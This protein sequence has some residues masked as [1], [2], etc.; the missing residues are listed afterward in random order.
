[1]TFDDEYLAKIEEAVLAE[2]L[3]YLEEQFSTH[4]SLVHVYFGANTW[5]HTAA[6]DGLTM[7]M[8]LLISLGCNVNAP[9]DDGK[10]WLP[11]NSVMISD[12]PE[13]LRILLEAGTD[14]NHDRVVISAITGQKKNSLV[15]LKLLE[16]FGANLNR[17]FMNELTNSPMN[18][19]TTAEDW[20]K[21]DVVDYLLSRRAVRPA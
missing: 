9:Q 10:E 1:M 4:P 18:A 3:P 17:V 16:Q 14:P 2:D 15:L 6:H 19:L 20:A 7:V 8:K 11:I 12:K 21:Q 5:L 13:A